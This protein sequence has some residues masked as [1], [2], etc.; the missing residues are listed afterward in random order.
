MTIRQAEVI[1]GL[2]KNNMNALATARAM[3]VHPNTI[4]YNVRMIHRN[5]GK[6]PLDFYDLCELLPEARAVLGEED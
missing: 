3:F 4:H 1:V 6:N 2:A 5:T